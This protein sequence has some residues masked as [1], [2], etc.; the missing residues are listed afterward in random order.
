MD[1]TDILPHGFIQHL[2]AT[3]IRLEE[4]KRSNL[5][6][7]AEKLFVEKI[8]SIKDTGLIALYYIRQRIIQDME[9]T[10]DLPFQPQ[11]KQFAYKRFQIML[12]LCSRHQVHKDFPC[13]VPSP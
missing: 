10:H 3:R 2:R 1:I 11:A 9:D 8:L 12:L 13:R 6:L 7:Q 4:R 5:K